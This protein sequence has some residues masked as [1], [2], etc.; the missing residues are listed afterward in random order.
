[1]WYRVEA[2][3]RADWRAGGHR[4][5]CQA[6][7]AAWQAQKEGQWAQQQH[8]AFDNDELSVSGASFLLVLCVLSINSSHRG[9]R[10]TVWGRAWLGAKQNE[11]QGEDECGAGSGE[12]V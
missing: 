11:A 3:S 2:C 6:L 5:V 7:A 4:K 1:M 9:K 10:G 12:Q 8:S